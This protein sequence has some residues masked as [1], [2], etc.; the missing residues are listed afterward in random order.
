MISKFYLCV[1]K[2]LRIKFEVVR[3]KGSKALAEIIKKK[4]VRGIHERLE[5]GRTV[6]NIS[7]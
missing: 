4:S 3:E 1:F 7:W 5:Q 6:N 2:L